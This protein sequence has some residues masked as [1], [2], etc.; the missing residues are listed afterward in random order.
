MFVVWGERQQKEKKESLNSATF[1]CV[2]SMFFL[3]NSFDT[4]RKIQGFK[5]KKIIKEVPDP[6][7]MLHSFTG[8][9]GIFR[10]L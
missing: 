9:M 1:W 3:E 10:T 4:V 2:E 5:E 7:V 8:Y 6:A